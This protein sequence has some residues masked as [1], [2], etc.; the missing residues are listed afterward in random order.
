VRST[1]A[2]MSLTSRGSTTSN[3][4]FSTEMVVDG[5]EPHELYTNLMNCAS[6]SM[7]CQVQREHQGSGVISDNS[8][9]AER[10]LTSWYH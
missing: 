2:S 8:R 5:H 10:Y 4:A 1:F 3:T 9:A 7:S 6:G